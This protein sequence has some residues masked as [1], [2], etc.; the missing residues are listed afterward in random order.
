VAGVD[1]PRQVSCAGRRQSCAS[2]SNF[3]TVTSLLFP[4]LTGAEAPEKPVGF[5]VNKLAGKVQPDRT[6]EA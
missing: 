2:T 3:P 6:W 4:T 5:I 1:R